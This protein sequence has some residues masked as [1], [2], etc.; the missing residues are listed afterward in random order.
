MYT[1]DIYLLNGA[2][3]VARTSWL[4]ETQSFMHDETV[5]SPMPR[6]RSVDVDTSLDLALVWVLL[7]AFQA[8]E[9]LRQ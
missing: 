8:T 7:S 6:D 3:Y 2:G 9:E 5:A 4:Q 1:P